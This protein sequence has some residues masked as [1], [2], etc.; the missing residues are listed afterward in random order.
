VRSEEELVDMSQQEFE[1]IIPHTKIFA[2]C[3]PQRKLAILTYLQNHNQIVAMTGDGV[4]DA[5]AL[6]KAHVGIAMGKI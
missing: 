2:R 3:T 5:P 4:N 1:R 6:K